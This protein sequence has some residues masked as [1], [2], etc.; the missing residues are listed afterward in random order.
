MISTGSW[1]LG[2]EKRRREVTTPPVP[3][4]E[5][6]KPGAGGESVPT[7][8][9]IVTMQSPRGMFPG[10]KSSH[11]CPA[12]HKRI[13]LPVALM[14]EGG[15]TDCPTCGAHLVSLGAHYESRVEIRRV[16]EETGSLLVDDETTT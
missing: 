3:A 2:R 11:E 5:T 7:E 4:P 10:L 16:A 15:K 12:C 13:S 14:L 8:G 6:V 1:R 9:P